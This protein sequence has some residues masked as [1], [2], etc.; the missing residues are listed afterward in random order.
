M[1]CT[2]LEGV[3]ALKYIF[4]AS[5]SCIYLIESQF[6]RGKAKRNSELRIWGLPSVRPPIFLPRTWTKVATTSDVAIIGDIATKGD[7]APTKLITTKSMSHPSPIILFHLL[8]I[9]SKCKV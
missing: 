6:V 9:T 2:D 3:N 1:G 5:G 8:N 4:R 7:I